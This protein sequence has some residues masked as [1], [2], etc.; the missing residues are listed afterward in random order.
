MIAIIQEFYVEFGDSELDSAIQLNDISLLPPR[1][2]LSPD[3]LKWFGDQIVASGTSIAMEVDPEAR[4]F[5]KVP[6][7]SWESQI[8]PPADMINKLYC[9]S[10]DMIDKFNPTLRFH[11]RDYTTQIT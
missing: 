7:I 6:E 5:L 9:D 1:K 3:I 11:V 8:W 10:V 2:R 4:A